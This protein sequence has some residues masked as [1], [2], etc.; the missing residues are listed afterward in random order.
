MGFSLKKHP[1]NKNVSDAYAQRGVNLGLQ[2]TSGNPAISLYTVYFCVCNGETGA[3]IC[4]HMYFLS[5]L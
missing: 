5:I 4:V 1:K 3:K 2:Y